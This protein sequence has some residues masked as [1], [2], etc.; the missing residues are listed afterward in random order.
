[1]SGRRLFLPT[2]LTA[3]ACAMTP[4]RASA[5]WLF[6]P[7]VGGNFGGNASFSDSNATFDDEVEKRVDF[8]A[9]LGWMGNGIVGFEV[10]FGYSPNFFANTIGDG[11]FEFGDSNATTLMGNFLV[12]APIG[13]QTGGGVRP[14]ASG[15]VGLIRTNISGG[16]FFDDLTT[17]DF[18]MNVGAG[19]HGFFTDHIGMRGDVRYFRSFQDHDPTGDFD[20]GL[21]SFDFWRASV[22]VTFRFGNE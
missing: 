21:G 7:F 16:D 19:L 5:D 6:T 8:G 3:F 15:G 4:V 11:D 13:G 1:M 17:N 20:L 18:G 14:Y 22:G 12:G 9:S 2:L 10:D